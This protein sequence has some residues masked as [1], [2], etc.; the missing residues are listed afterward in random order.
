MK[1]L[2][3]VRWVLWTLMAALCAVT[4]RVAAASAPQGQSA[5]AAGYQAYLSGDRAGAIQQLQPSA[6]DAGVLE[7]YALFFLAQAQLDSNDLDGAQANFTRLTVGYPE[8]L[9]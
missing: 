1:P 8:S 7:D 6:T 9:Y 3:L 4:L 5:F 2:R